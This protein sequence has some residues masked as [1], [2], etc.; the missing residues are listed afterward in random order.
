MLAQLYYFNKRYPTVNEEDK[1]TKTGIF[2]FIIIS[3]CLLITPAPVLSGEYDIIAQKI[4]DAF[5]NKKSRPLAS[6]KFKNLTVDQAYEIQTTLVKLRESKGEICMGYRA[7]LWSP[8]WQN[9][10]RLDGPV[11]GYLFKSMLRWPGT[12]YLKN[13]ARLYIESEIGFRF[14]KDI[15]KPVDDI[16]VLKRAVAITFP[17]IRLADAFYSS[18]RKLRGVDL[19]ASNDNSRKV[20]IGKAAKAQDLNAVKVTLFHNGQKI[21][22]GIGSHAGDDQWQALQWV[23]NDVLAKGGEVKDGDIVIT[24]NLTGPNRVK[25]GKYVADYGSFGKIEF[26]CK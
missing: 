26:E 5:I 15:T 11:R 1:M 3:V 4:E 14:Q 21:G 2:V 12:I 18:M 24:G 22:G 10:F 25:P 6:Q 19:I 7:G 23:V 8:K 13:H 17:A 16:K 20:L 9:R